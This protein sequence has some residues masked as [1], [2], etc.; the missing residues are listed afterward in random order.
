[1]SNLTRRGLIFIGIVLLPFIVGLL[2]TYEVIKFEYVTDMQHQPSISYQDG[3]SL[4]PPE[5]S[6]STE[7]KA[8][9]LDTVS[10]NPVP[11]DGV[12]LQRGKIL[13]SIHCELCHGKMGHG[14]GPLAD[15]YLERVPS[16]LTEPQVALQFDGV[17]FRTISLGFSDMPGLAE[18]LTVR[19]RWDVINYLRTLEE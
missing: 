15:H 9:I 7:G 1:M 11:A 8:I 6:V 16:D 2:I 17:L 18:N 14:D 4:M 5:E 3:P 19:E 10:D 13:Y 12:S